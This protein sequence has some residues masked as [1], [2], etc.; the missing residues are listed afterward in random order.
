[1]NC[2]RAWQAAHVP[3]KTC[4]PRSAWAGQY[5]AA[6]RFGTRERTTRAFGSMRRGTGAPVGALAVSLAPRGGGAAVAGAGALRDAL[7]HPM[8][9]IVQATAVERLT[10]MMPLLVRWRTRP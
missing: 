1:M 2:E 9:M 5:V 6:G 10:C 3:L 8:A 7:A 4:S